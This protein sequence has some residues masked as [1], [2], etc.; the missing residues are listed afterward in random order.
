MIFWFVKYD[1]KHTNVESGLEEAMVGNFQ[2][3]NIFF[4]NA[5]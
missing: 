4:S 5:K 1:R 2:G 3:S